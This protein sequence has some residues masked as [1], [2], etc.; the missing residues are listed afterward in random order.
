MAS[1]IRPKP[2]GSCPIITW[3]FMTFWNSRFGH[4]ALGGRTGRL[5]NNEH[6]LGRQLSPPILYHAIA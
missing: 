2:I 5:L 6:G 4:S 1:L 3:P